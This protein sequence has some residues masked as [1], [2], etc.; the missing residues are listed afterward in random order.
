MK[1]L[2]SGIK[3]TGEMTLG[4][5]IGALRQF[6]NLQ[7]ELTD[8]EFYIFIADLHAITTPQEKQ[9]LRKNIKTIAALYIACGLDPNRVNLF[10]QSEVSEHAELGYI[11][12]S[13][14]YIGEMER[15]I[16]FKEKRQTQTEGIRTSLLTYPALMA[17]DI[18]LYDAD[19]VPVGEDQMQHLE[20]TRTA[21]N[22]FNYLYGE[23]F[24]EPEGFTPKTGA[25]IM[26]LQNP[27]SKMSK[28]STANS[29]DYILILDDLAVIKNK[30]KSAVTD[31]DTR[32]I[33]DKENKPGISN[34]LTIYSA[35]S[36]LSIKDLEKKYENESYGTFKSDLADVVANEL[37]PIQKRFNEIINSKELDDYLDQGRNNAKKIA[38][39]K[40]KKVYNKIG[41]GRK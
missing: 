14:L 1:R 19:L 36:S 25:R 29:K 10:I 13:T 27:T 35:L 3:P 37:A 17:A 24:K 16:Q 7:N 21:A 6:V 39:R 28:S 9:T 26:G 4:N 2:V 12:E 8:T 32:I 40:L 34:L 20:I 18:L 30:I 41:L 31:S 23:T 11:M 15:M 38:E 33:F 22:R 5:Y